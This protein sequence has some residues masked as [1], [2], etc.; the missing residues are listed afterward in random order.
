MIPKDLER[1]A[2]RFASFPEAGLSTPSPLYEVLSHSVSAD[3]DLLRIAAQA[4]PGQP[5]PNLLLAAVHYLILRGAPGDLR[6]YYPSFEPDRLREG[7]PVTAF[8]DFCLSNRDRIVRLLETRR[9]Q[10]NVIRRCSYLY[11]V[12]AEISRRACGPLALIE[13]GSSA[14]LQ[15]LW[16]R[17]A[18]LYGENATAIGEP[19]SSVV[20][21]S[22]IR[23]EWI[24][25]VPERPP[26][27]AYRVGTDINVL[28]LEDADDRLWLQSLIWPEHAERVEE[29]EHAVEIW[30]QHPQRIVEGDGIELLPDL[31]REAPDDG[32][33]CVFH[34]HVANQFSAEQKDLL[35]ANLG[36]IARSRD[37]YHVYNNLFDIRLHVDHLA[38]CLSH[39]ILRLEVDGHGRWFRWNVSKH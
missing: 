4:P 25:E 3:P 37:V 39:E 35:L 31:A 33:L 17:Y 32:L 29:L 5:V 19:G 15:L 22:E 18:Y 23:G 6:Y 8:R 26:E 11:A 1:L 27:V 13:I 30:G 9:V 16:D 24:P 38:G 12:F 28:R 10:T 14:G 36:K 7:S 34:T 2:R 21:Q 20:V